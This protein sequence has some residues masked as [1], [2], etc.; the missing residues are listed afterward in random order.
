MDVTRYELLKCHIDRA[1][2]E[3]SRTD[4]WISLTKS[5]K[6]L[7]RWTPEKNSNRD[8]FHFTKFESKLV[9]FL[10]VGELNLLTNKKREFM[11]RYGGT[12]CLVKVCGGEDEI[13]HITKCFGYSTQCPKG[14]NTKQLAEY[15]VA[16][17]RERIKKFNL[18]LIYFRHS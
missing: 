16:L 7:M 1:V 15:L 3:N 18:P 6:V 17:N 2:K 9:F 12:H 14:G 5:S 8:Y 13:D 10:F 4:T 11:S